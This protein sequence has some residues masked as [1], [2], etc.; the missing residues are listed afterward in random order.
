MT[1]I[2]LFTW[3]CE[4][5]DICAEAT[6]TTPRLIIRF[7]DINNPEDFKD[8]R[9]LEID[10]LDDDGNPFDME[11]PILVRTD[12]DSINLP[13]R[14]QAENEITTTRFRLTKD[15][16]FEDDIDDDGND[17]LTTA[18]NDD[19][20]TIRYTP[21]FVYVSRACGYKSIFNLDIDDP[22]TRDPDDIDIWTT[23]FEIINFTI[24]N[25]NAAQINIFH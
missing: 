19:I 18:S 21:E 25:E 2:A 17:D 6:P 9:Q 20:I 1:L 23:S 15:A 8:V 7:Y 14:F 4:R 24:E 13:L 16:D 5:D 3:S 10:G 22:V 12:T 11:N